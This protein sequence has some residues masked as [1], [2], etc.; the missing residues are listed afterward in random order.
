MGPAMDERHA[1]YKAVAEHKPN[2]I[3]DEM[4]C[5]THHNGMRIAWTRVEFLRDLALPD[6]RWAIVDC[7]AGNSK[8]SLVCSHREIVFGVLPDYFKAMERELEIN[9]YKKVPR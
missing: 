8:K 3:I 5:R 6:Y 9:G 4:L 7:E 2:V 1:T